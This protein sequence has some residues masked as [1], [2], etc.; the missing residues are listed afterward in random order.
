MLH[1]HKLSVIILVKKEVFLLPPPLLMRSPAPL[2]ADYGNTEQ[3]SLSS[4]IITKELE[5]KG[6]IESE[7]DQ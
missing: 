4:M 1:K 6:G 5:E 3:F 2:G 7:A